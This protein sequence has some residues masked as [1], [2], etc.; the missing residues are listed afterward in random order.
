MRQAEIYRNG[1]L[2]GVI[3]QYP[4]KRYEFRYTDEW[5]QNNALPA[6]SLTLPKTQQVYQSDHLFPFF[7]NMLSEGVNRQLQARQ[8]RI[9]E[10]DYFGLLIATAGA[11]TIGAVTVKPLV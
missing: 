2:A 3:T 6:I 10:K 9:D 7:F 8:L 5:F 1:T 4:E 11:D